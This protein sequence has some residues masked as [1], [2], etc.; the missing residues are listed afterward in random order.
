MKGRV[1]R[2]KPFSSYSLSLSSSSLASSKTNEKNIID[3]G[4]LRVFSGI[5]PT[6]TLHIGNYI[7]ALQQWVELQHQFD[8]NFCI[9][10]LHALTIPQKSSIKEATLKTAA[11]YLAAGL[12]PKKC[13]IFVQSHVPAH[14][15]LAWILNCFTPMGWL[16]RMIQ[17][18]EKAQK[19][20]T[21][22][23]LGLYAYPVLMA[24]DI[25]LYKASIVPVGD[26]QKQHLELARDLVAKFQ[27]IY[28]NSTA[29]C[30]PHPMILK[31]GSRLMSL[32]NGNV[33]MSKS[34][35]DDNT[36]INI[37]DPPD[38]ILKKFKSCK[39]D[40]FEGLEW[41]NPSR[42]EAANLLTIYQAVTNLSKEDALSEVQKMKWSQFKS[43]LSEAVVEKLKPIQ[44]KYAELVEKGNDF[45]NVEMVLA[46]GCHK[47]NQIAN[48]NLV[49]VK[50][51]LHLI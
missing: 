21:S 26:D 30:L 43:V 45:S 20:P 37:L 1:A 38:I 4:N 12:D 19:S 14:S 39:T 44:S 27:H 16:D 51:V 15:E 11:I 40:S 25:L 24:A 9:V 47:A 48:S 8:C 13:T 50:R 49:E 33:K 42:P 2:I 29:F 23:N 18:K 32:K 36:R 3:T 46:Q 34:D 31:S 6:G 41:D 5:Q 10:D 35:H 22:P 28:P 17:F 7:G